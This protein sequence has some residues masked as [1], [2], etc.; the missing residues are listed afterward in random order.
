V[1]FTA[2]ARDAFAAAAS[3]AAF[4][5][6][7]L[8]IAALETEPAVVPAFGG[9]LPKTEP[10][11]VRADDVAGVWDEAVAGPVVDAPAA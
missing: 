5:R 11:G 4:A 10:A 9:G 7:A 3:A 2:R 6:E 1:T 8:E